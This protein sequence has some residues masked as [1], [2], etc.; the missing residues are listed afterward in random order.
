MAKPKR[1]TGQ[2]AVNVKLSKRTARLKTWIEANPGAVAEQF[3]AGKASEPSAVLYKVMNKIFA[4]LSVRPIENVILKCDPHLA[5]LLR[6]RYTGI[7]HR[8]HLDR[9]YWIS[10]TL[11]ADVPGAVVKRLISQSYELVCARLARSQVTELARLTA[12]GT[13]LIKIGKTAMS[14]GRD[15]RK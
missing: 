8:S 5:T 9:R 11:D 6:E 15:R 3:C 2:S 13:G 10:V 1:G 14:G 7:G 4:I 12:S